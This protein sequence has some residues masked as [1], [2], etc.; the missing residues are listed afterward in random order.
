[1]TRNVLACIFTSSAHIIVVSLVYSSVFP[2]LVVFVLDFC[3]HYLSLVF[4]GPLTSHTGAVRTTVL[5]RLVL[6]IT[7]VWAGGYQGVLDTRILLY[8]AYEID[9]LNPEADCT[10]GFACKGA[11]DKDIG[12][13][14]GGWEK[15]KSKGARANINEIIA[16]ISRLR[17]DPKRPFG[18]DSSGNVVP[19]ADGAKDIDVEQTAK[20]LY[21]KILKA[22][23]SKQY[24]NGLIPNTPPFKMMKGATGNYIKILGKRCSR[25]PKRVPTIPTIR[26]YLTSSKKSST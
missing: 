17:P 26:N 21:P 18:R 5:L 23:K 13:C 8:L 16:P 15:Y 2:W 10:I 20:Y 11:F 7:S 19:L 9:G 4:V 12:K 22:T 25:R 3:N 1:M 14:P 6:F 24:P